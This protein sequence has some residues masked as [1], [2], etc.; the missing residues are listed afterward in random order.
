M[1]NATAL[2]LRSTDL[3]AAGLSAVDIIGVRCEAMVRITASFVEED[4]GKAGLEKKG[5]VAT[6]CLAATY[7]STQSVASLT[8]AVPLRFPRD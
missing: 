3:E 1:L 2:D 4:F 7:H 8:R 5:F 6:A